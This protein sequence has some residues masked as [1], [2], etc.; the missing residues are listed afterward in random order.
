MPTET[1]IEN[2]R[3]NQLNKYL[4]DICRKNYNN[5]GDPLSLINKAVKE[6][7]FSTEAMDGIYC[8]RDGRMHDQIGKRTW[9]SIQWHKFE[10]ANR[11]EINAY[12]S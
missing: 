12:A 10:D 11:W 3:K 4:G 8:G 6:T 2:K 5:L 9:I 1:Q 7:G